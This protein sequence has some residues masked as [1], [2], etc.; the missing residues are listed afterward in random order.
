VEIQNQLKYLGGSG[1]VSR[2]TMAVAIAPG[3]W[4]RSA[5]AARSKSNPNARAATIWFMAGPWCFLSHGADDYALVPPAA[6]CSST[7]RLSISLSQNPSEA[8]RSAPTAMRWMRAAALT[9]E[10]M[11]FHVELMPVETQAKF[12]FVSSGQT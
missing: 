4:V 1:S 10:T 8:G 6:P 12:H 5:C 7:D 11:M 9:G 3:K 2:K